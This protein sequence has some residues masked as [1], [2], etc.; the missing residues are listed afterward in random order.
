MQKELRHTRIYTKKGKPR[1]FVY[2]RSVVRVNGR[3]EASG[4]SY[5]RYYIEKV[6]GKKIGKGYVVHHRDGNQMNDNPF[7]LK[8]ISASAHNKIHMINSVLEKFNRT[9][10]NNCGEHVKLSMRRMYKIFE[11]SIKDKYG[12]KLEIVRLGGVSDAAG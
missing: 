9:K 7:N 1:R 5:G 11:E 3:Y 10:C 6:S 8:L 12:A 2:L 4:M